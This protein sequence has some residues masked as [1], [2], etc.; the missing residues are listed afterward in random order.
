MFSAVS[1]EGLTSPVFCEGHDPAVHRQDQRRLQ[2]HP[3][4][5]RHLLGDRQ[6]PAAEHLCLLRSRPHLR[7]QLH[8]RP[9]RLS[10]ARS[11]PQESVRRKRQAA[12][13]PLFLC[14]NKVSGLFQERSPQRSSSPSP[15][16][17]ACLSASLD[18]ASSN[19]VSGSCPLPH[20]A[21][22]EPGS[23]SNNPPEDEQ[24]FSLH[25]QSS[26][27]W[28]SASRRS[29]SSSWSPEP[30]TSTMTV[31]SFSATSCGSETFPDLHRL[32]PPLRRAP[33]G[34][35]CGGRGGRSP[36]DDEL[37]AFRLGHGLRRRGGPH[38]GLP[39]GLRGALHAAG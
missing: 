12:N 6:G 27:A 20:S 9:G 10:D 35:G 22:A 36:P 3:R 37:V 19:V 18:I 15:A 24:T 29:S 11:A 14:W 32:R 31:R 28:A 39:G 7:L 25:G 30:P 26:S 21:T 33:G 8:L 23:G 4:S 13:V 17:P 16:W 2:L 1:S 34:V 38:A 5:G